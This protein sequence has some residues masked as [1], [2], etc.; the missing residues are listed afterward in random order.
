[1]KN[2]KKLV[3]TALVGVFALSLIGCNMIEK[4]PEG[5]RK[6]TVAKVNGKKITRG[7]VDAELNDVIEQV[8]EKYGENYAKNSEAKQILKQQ[9]VT[10][11]DGMIQEMIIEDKAKELNVMPD[12]KALQ[13][14][15]EKKLQEYKEMYGGEEKFEEALKT[16]KITVEDLKKIAE[17][18]TITEKVYDESTKDIVVEEDEIK[19]YYNSYQE[20]FTEQ[21]NKMHLAEILLDNEDTANEVKTKLD[22]G[23]D[24]SE[25][26][27]EYS[28][29]KGNKDNGGDLGFINY[30]DRTKLNTMIM[31]AAKVLKEGDYTPPMPDDKGW[32]IVKVIEKQEYPVKK[33]DD[34]RED[35]EKVL[36][37]QKSSESWYKLKEQW[38]KDA[39]IKK[40]EKN[41]E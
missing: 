41:L 4:T 33:L 16:S 28:I 21:P 25:L 23:A 17:R 14:A 29:D 18:D 3:S 32:H 27:K 34:V 31:T 22:E 24:F 8:K 30:T 6:S 36:K 5:I 39:K 12:E 37:S 7:E 40:Y 38:N 11:L 13:E 35:I 10:V 1:M 15:V 2:I 9:R 19:N 20:Q 26:A